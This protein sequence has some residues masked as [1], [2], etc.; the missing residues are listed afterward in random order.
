MRHLQQLAT[1]AFGLALVVAVNVGAAPTAR[2]KDVCIASPTGG[3]TLNAFILRDVEPLS[4][5]RAITLRGLY[6]PTGTNSMAPLHGSAT[7][8][9]DG[10][11]RIGFFVHASAESTN[12]FTVSGVSTADFDGVLK[13]DSDGDFKPNG[14]LDLTVVDCS[15]LTI[16]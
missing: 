8:V 3:G 12:D 5:G 15:T 13:F 7:M 10:S 1:V 9:S 11:V 2:T 16:P 4:R 14:I 6:F